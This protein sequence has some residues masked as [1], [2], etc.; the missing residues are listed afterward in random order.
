MTWNEPPPTQIVEAALNT[1]D[2]FSSTQLHEG[3]NNAILSWQFDLS[4][5][6]FTSLVIL[7]GTTIIA[8]VGSSGPGPQPGF[9]NQYGI[10]WISSQNFVRLIIFRV[11]F[12]QNGTFTCLVTAGEMTGFG[13]FQFESIVQVDVVG[14]LKVKIY[15]LII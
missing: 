15:E 14:K 2:H 8:G 1:V 10:D 3:T 13:S 4:D 5:L 9:E 11:T 6:K 12:A 7:F